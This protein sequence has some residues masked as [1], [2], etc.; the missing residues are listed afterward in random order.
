VKVWCAYSLEPE[1]SARRLEPDQTKRRARIQLPEIARESELQG[2]NL[3]RNPVAQLA[4]PSW[5]GKWIF[6][7]SLSVVGKS[8]ESVANR[9]EILRIPKGVNHQRGDGDPECY[10]WDGA[11]RTDAFHG[12]KKS[13]RCL[14]CRRLARAR[15]KRI[16]IEV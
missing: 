3:L 11:V 10:C 1:S 4:Q 15:K 6:I 14:A 5:L 16:G 9:T 7:A 2:F 13:A 8:S 12:L